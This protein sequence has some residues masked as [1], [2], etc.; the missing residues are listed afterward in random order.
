MESLATAQMIYIA[1]R[2]ATL[3]QLCCFLTLL[4]ILVFNSYHSWKN[5]NQI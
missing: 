3:V 5:L 4:S 2:C 1:S